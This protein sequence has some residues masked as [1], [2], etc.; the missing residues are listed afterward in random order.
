LLLDWEK[1]VPFKTKQ[2]DVLIIGGGGAGALAAIEASKGEKLQ[3]MLV[4]KGPI[5]MSG[6]TPTANGGT[7]GAGPEEYLFNL[8]ITVGRFLNDQDIAWF[9]THEIKNALE[10]LKALDVPVVPLRAR[11]VAVQSTETLQKLR[12]HIVHTRNIELHED[13]LVTRLLA[14][15]NGV[16]GVITLNLVT[17]ELLAIEAKAIVLATGGSTGELY[18]ASSNNPFG[19]STDA[20]G[21]GHVMAF[22]AGAEL[23]DME[24]IQFLPLPSNSRCLYIRYF[25]EFWNGPYHNRFGDVIEDDISRYGAASYSA[26]LMQ[27]IFFE[28]QNGRGPVYIDQRSNTAIDAKLLIKGWEQRRRLIKS[29]GIDPREHKIEL[30]LGSHFSMGGVKVNA[31]TETTLPGLFATGEMMGAVH[32]A[33]RLSGYSFSQMIVFG[34]EGGKWAAEFARR[35]QRVDSIPIE[36]LEIEGEQLRKFMAPKEDPLRVAF[37][38]DRL[39]QVMERHVFIV[40]DKNGLLEAIRDIESIERD[41]ARIQVPP[42]VRFNLEL[43][44]AIEFPY[45]VE[46]ARIVAHSALAREES[47][48]FHYRSDFPKEDNARWLRHTTARLDGGKLVIGSS[49]VE[50][51]HMRPEA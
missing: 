21:T 31:K 30:L 27:K 2:C 35:A 48:G 51:N 14:S 10:M 5:G 29:L 42:F 3:V 9:M 13:L 43:V 7:A 36:E 34:F 46:A 33:C 26:E 19:I 47:R 45:L 49:P 50:L 38:K 32:G 1:T 40:R 37:L 18:P 20:S 4:C 28:M 24:M 23:V 39:K 8:M 6:L 12:S 16:S 22:R 15:G 41:I 25:P 44:R 17:G 11:S